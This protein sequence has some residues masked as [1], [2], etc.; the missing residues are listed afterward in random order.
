[1]LV[2]REL[3]GR[4][5]L[6]LPMP[7]L[8]DAI[9]VGVG[10]LYRQ[11]GSKDELIAA[12]V[13]ERA[14]ILRDRFEASLEDAD[15]W[16]AL[17]RVTHETVDDCIDDALSQTA[18]DEASFASA[19]VRQARAEATESLARVV[20]RAARHGA[21]RADVDH[22]DLRI[23]FCSLREL[24]GL[25]PDSAH[26]LAELVLRGIR[27]RREGDEDDA[28]ASGAGAA[29]QSSGERLAEPEQVP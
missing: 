27:A 26:R 19:E 8:A 15:P 6:D 2:A 28:A 29:R 5:G 10:S 16:R 18:W 9:G 24:S 3:F 21:L 12:L 25:E 22:Q 4:E 20:A 7:A 11:I 1:M 14:L 23:L 17:V 13:V